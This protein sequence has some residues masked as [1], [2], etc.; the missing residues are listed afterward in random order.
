[1]KW[2]SSDGRLIYAF[3]LLSVLLWPS[4]R[5]EAQFVTQPPNVLPDSKLSLSR[6]DHVLSSFART[7]FSLLPKSLLQSK[8]QIVGDGSASD[9]LHSGYRA[10]DKV[11]RPVEDPHSKACRVKLFPALWQSFQFL[12]IQMSVDLGMDP[13]ER[14]KLVNAIDQGK[15][16]SRYWQTLENFRYSHY[17]DDDTIKTTYLG[18]P[19]MGAETEFIWIQNN[20]R[21]REIEFSNTK[22]Y[23]KSRLWAMI[24]TTICSF[25]WLLGPI[26]ES[27][28]GNQGINYYVDKQI[29]KRTNGTGY[30]DFIITPVGGLLWAVGEDWLDLHVGKKMRRKRNP[31]MLLLSAFV[32][33]VKS[34]A[35]ILRY[36]PPWYRDAE[37]PAS[38]G[39]RD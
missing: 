6:S 8:S 7:D 23:W 26:S 24:P 22:N 30:V 39:P 32:I 3:G 20:P 9:L 14:A 17:N 36:K 4:P 31:G 28:M 34:G 5:T 16:W 12:S 29:H 18:H 10:R 13:N 11:C 33:P 27:A 21:Y 15:F 19:M 38:R 1:M 35:S 37:H 25:E 2:E